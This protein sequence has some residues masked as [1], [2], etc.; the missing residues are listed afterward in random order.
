MVG[1]FYC[2]AYFDKVDQILNCTDC[3]IMNESNYL[4]KP[5]ICLTVY[6]TFSTASC[7]RSRECFSAPIVS[8]L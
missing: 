4:A 2:L 8:L 1:V 6:K 3:T 5:C 7:V